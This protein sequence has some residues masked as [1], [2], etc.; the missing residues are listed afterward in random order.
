MFSLPFLDCSL[1]NL[2]TFGDNAEDTKYVFKMYKC[3]DT[4]L[5]KDRI[6][7][8][9]KTDIIDKDE[10]NKTDDDTDG[11]KSGKDTWLSSSNIKD[12]TQLIVNEN[13]VTNILMVV[14]NT[15]KDLGL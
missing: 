7:E 9:K 4:E 8:I 13:C 12:E 14:E 11:K 6:F 15:F 3:N 2:T 5:F 10:Q 1:S